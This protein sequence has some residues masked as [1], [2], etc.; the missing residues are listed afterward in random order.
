MKVAN[1]KEF[2]DKAVIMF[3]STETVFI[4]EQGKVLGFYLPV[5]GEAFSIKL[6]RDLQVAIAESV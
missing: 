3:K 4:I 2:R 1:M 6:K 5:K